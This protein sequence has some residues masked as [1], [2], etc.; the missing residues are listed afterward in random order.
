MLLMLP[1]FG[2]ICLLSV[3]GFSV[4]F[5]ASVHYLLPMLL[6]ISSHL[7]SHVFLFSSNTTFLT[8][9]LVDLYIFLSSTSFVFNHFR[10]VFLLF[11]LLFDIVCPPY[12]FTN[13]VYLGVI[14]NVSSLA[15]CRAYC[16]MVMLYSIV[17][18]SIPSCN[19]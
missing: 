6:S 2:I 11:Y 10:C 7:L 5:H 16:N 17:L 15:S 14:P 4:N 18:V 13:F 1:V 3:P 19:L 9:A 8:S 12:L